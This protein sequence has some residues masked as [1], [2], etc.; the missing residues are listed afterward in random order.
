MPFMGGL[1]ELTNESEGSDCF[2]LSWMERMIGAAVCGFFSFF[3]GTVS[4]MAIAL[5]RIRK[6]ALLFAIMNIMLFLSL[7]FLIGFKKLLS[8]LTTKERRIAAITMFLGM[9][10]TMF[11]AFGKTRLIGVILG[12]IIEFI[13]FVFIA[14]SYVPMGRALFQ[15]IFKF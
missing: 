8:S 7:G 5:L 15:K 2:N 10:I 9:F 6:F 3:A 14:L 12:F 11:F 1:I 4:I 13:S